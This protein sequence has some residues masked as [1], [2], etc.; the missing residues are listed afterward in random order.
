LFSS[1]R[2][3]ADC[4]LFWLTE[5]DYEEVEEENFNSTNEILDTNLMYGI[6]LESEQENNHSV[7]TEITEDEKTLQ[8]EEDIIS[9]EDDDLLTNDLIDMFSL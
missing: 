4:S 1:K 9:S 5:W 6:L 7:I 2:R 8:Q 3:W